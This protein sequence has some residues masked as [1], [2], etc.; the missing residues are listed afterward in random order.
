[1]DET[2]SPGNLLKDQFELAVSSA[3]AERSESV[4]KSK[5]SYFII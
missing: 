1:V 5:L 4:D 2:S 3:G